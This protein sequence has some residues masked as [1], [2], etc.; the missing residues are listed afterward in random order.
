MPLQASATSSSIGASWMMLPSR[1]TGTPNTG[2]KSLASFDARICRGKVIWLK[3]MAGIGMARSRTSRGKR[4]SFRNC[5][6]PKQRINPASRI[7]SETR[8]RN[9][10][11]P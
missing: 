11:A 5:Q 9:N 10:S 8:E 7:T 1:K 4:N 6:P 2:S 3:M